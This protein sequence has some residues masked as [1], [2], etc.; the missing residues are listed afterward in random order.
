MCGSA[1]CFRWPSSCSRSCKR[2]PWLID[3]SLC[4]VMGWMIESSRQCS[5]ESATKVHPATLSDAPMSMTAFES[6]CPC[7]LWIVRAYRRRRGSCWR[8]WCRFPEFHSKVMGGTGMQPG[9]SL[10]IG[11]V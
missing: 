1:S 2:R 8:E 4:S 9:V 3:S 7:D 6:V 10:N 11:P 5:L